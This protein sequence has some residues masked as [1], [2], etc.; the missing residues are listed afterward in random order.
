MNTTTRWIT[1]LTLGLVV[2]APGAHADYDEVHYYLTYVT[3]RLIGYTPEQAYRVAAADAAVNVSPLTEPLQMDAADFLADVDPDTPER[4]RPRWMFHGYT[5]TMRL[6]KA[7]RL[8]KTA[9]DVWSERVAALTD[10][11]DDEANRNP[12]VLLHYVQDKHAHEQLHSL[13]SGYLQATAGSGW[14]DY[15]QR[16]DQLGRVTATSL[17][18][19]LAHLAPSQRRNALTDADL[20]VVIE[21]F[22]GANAAPE[23]LGAPNEAVYQKWA[24]N[25]LN[26]NAPTRD[27]TNEQLAIMQRR[28]RGPDLA[29][30][31][32][33]ARN[34]LNFYGMTDPIP[35]V[36]T[37]RGQ[38]RFD[39]AGN[40]L[41]ELRDSYVLT[42]SLRVALQSRDGQPQEPVE[43]T[44]KGLPTQA[45]QTEY[46]LTKPLKL[47]VPASA[48]W[49]NL[50]VGKVTVEL[51]RN[52]RMVQRQENVVLDK[53][54]Q[55]VVI[56]VGA[57]AAA[58]GPVW[59]LKDGFPQINPDNVGP[60]QGSPAAAGI[61][62]T[63][64]TLTRLSPTLIGLRLVHHT[65]DG[66][67]VAYTL[68]WVLSQEPPRVL[69]WQQP[70]TLNITGQATPAAPPLANR[71]EI[72]G[73][74][75]S[76]ASDTDPGGANALLSFGKLGN[77]DGKPVAGTNENLQFTPSY[78]RSDPVEL[79][80][81]VG[82]WKIRWEWAQQQAA[83][84]PVTPTP[85]GPQV[86]P[87]DAAPPAVKPTPPA[88]QGATGARLGV[89]VKVVQGANGP[90]VVI[91]AI[92]EDSPMAGL[93][94][95]GEVILNVDGTLITSTEQIR[96]ILG[97]KQP[98][99]T[100]DLQLRSAE[101]FISDMTVRL[102]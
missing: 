33:A 15:Q 20:R 77:W 60:R 81:A 39:A 50:P 59:V 16:G 23:E 1:V 70:V 61:A 26:P 21:A 8:G 87:P 29:A 7:D 74:G 83:A 97:K 38:F 2:A 41:P 5:D 102:N 43:V 52:G 40:V 10:L 89:S 55:E 18:Q 58:A 98:G 63:E 84:A 51:R 94:E 99:D 54:T 34:I 27:F 57:P 100:I 13:L 71:L 49:S 17:T 76:L 53:Q 32:A 91:A 45:R 11:A 25:Q 4:Q 31:A 24:L 22:R 66:R 56:Q 92:T 101:G 19:A 44:L 6:L 47:N 86:A 69:N 36:R 96:Q 82:P 35:D 75:L 65:A 42:G 48:A 80:V 93:V 3:A 9:P 72:S 30:A 90:E 88:P 85:P 78:L 95:P 67:E 79:N 14:L 62:W 12:G 28:W 68:Q 37:A 64:T 73:F 46:D